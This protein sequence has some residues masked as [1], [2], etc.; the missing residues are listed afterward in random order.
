MTRGASELR[1]YSIDDLPAPPRGRRGWP[2]TEAPAA[3][4]PTAPDGT[5]WPQI[6]I[7]TP[8]FN[9]AEYLEETIRSVLLQ[10]YPNLEYFVFDGGS[11]DGSVEILRRYDAFLDSWVS[12]PDKGQ[13]D[14][15]NK[16]L[17]K[18]TGAIVN[19]LCSD[20]VL[21]PGALGHVGRTFV[22]RL[23]SDVVAGAGKYQFDDHSEPDYVS[24]R[25]DDDLSFLPGQNKIVQP[26]C[27]FRRTLLQ[28]SAAVRTDLHY[29]M[30]AELWCYF[31]A[32][33]ATWVFLPEVLS[34]YRITGAN[35]AFTGRWKIL[36]E[37]ERIY[38][39]YCGE[40]VPLTFWMRRFWRPLDRAGRVRQAGVLQRVSS[41]GARAVAF[42]LRAFYPRQR[43][44]GLQTSFMWYDV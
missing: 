5:P 13:S 1:T 7:V 41:L 19:W 6:S 8:S 4:P 14:A 11:T 38:D 34:V 25:A 40:R 12:G 42:F 30:D 32:Q 18:S 31:M 21:C 28:R 16:G 10:G 22:E 35:K 29:A 36:L 37:L 2:W 20:D 39:E 9:Q 24:T 33:N 17:A 44:Q 3:L 43:I 26:S 15:I 23:G 27:F